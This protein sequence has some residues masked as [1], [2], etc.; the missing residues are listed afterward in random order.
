MKNVILASLVALA[1]M[2]FS[3]NM[4]VAS[5]GASEPTPKCGEGKCGDDKKD[6]PTPKCA[7]GKC[8]GDK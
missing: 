2:A 6:K 4:V 1:M 7:S 5:D 3:T 8:G